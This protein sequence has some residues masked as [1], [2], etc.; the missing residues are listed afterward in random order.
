ME[1]ACPAA[2][3]LDPVERG[4]APLLPLLMLRST[5]NPKAG[6]RTSGQP[7]PWRSTAEPI[8]LL[9]HHNSEVAT[10]PPRS[11]TC[12]NRGNQLITHRVRAL[13]GDLAGAGI[14]VT[15]AAILETKRT[16]VQA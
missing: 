15:T 14:G 11:A 16:D 8:N 9:Q 1:R 4:L 5:E 10:P 6:P 13:I 12:G 3:D 7:A 2:V